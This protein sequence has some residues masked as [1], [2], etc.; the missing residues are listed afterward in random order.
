MDLDLRQDLGH[1]VDIRLA[2]DEAG[3]R[4]GVR[5]SR[6]V[7]AAAESDLESQLG[8]L[9][10]EQIRWRGRRRRLYSEREPRQQMVDQMG[11]MGAELVTLT[12][13]EERAL[14]V[15]RI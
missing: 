7:L 10:I 8:P 12:P 1:A 6:E 13:A 11:L 3:R 9:R 5:F 14:I 2:A 15:I 4:E